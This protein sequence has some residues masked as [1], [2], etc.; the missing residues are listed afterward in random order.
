MSMPTTTIFAQISQIWTSARLAL[1]RAKHPTLSAKTPLDH[2]R[3]TVKMA[4][5]GMAEQLALVGPLFACRLNCGVQTA[6]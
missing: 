2:I 6:S 4:S 3:V 1:I 5:R